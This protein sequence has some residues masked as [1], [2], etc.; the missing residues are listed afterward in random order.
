LDDI[1]QRALAVPAATPLAPPARPIVQTPPSPVSALAPVQRIAAL[2]PVQG[3]SQGV[4]DLPIGAATSIGGGASF[5]IDPAL[6]GRA[7][8]RKVV[9]R[10]VLFLALVFGGLLAAMAYSYTPQSK[11]LSP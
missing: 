10:L 2:P 7:R 8:R 6:D 5:E 1:A 11:F 4:R 9:W 3:V